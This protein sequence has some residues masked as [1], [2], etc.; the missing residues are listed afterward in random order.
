MVTAL[1]LGWW[2]AALI[3]LATL[4]TNFVN[5]DMSALA[6]KSLRPSLGDRSAIWTIGI[7]GGALSLLSSGLLDRFAAF[8][9][10][11]GALLVPVGGILLAHYVVRRRPVSVPDLYDPTGPYARRMGW[12]LAGT[13][14]W[15]AGAAAFW[16]AGGIGSTLPCLLVSVGVFGLVSRAE[17]PKPR[18]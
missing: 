1:N 10:L 13:V 9:L 14:A 11:L 18:A 6:L 17:S 16:M 3:T 4:T 2:G 15:A 7:V 12:S 8:T 5:I